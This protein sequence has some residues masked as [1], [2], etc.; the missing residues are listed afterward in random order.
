MSP[1]DGA[2]TLTAHALLHIPKNTVTME[3]T[4][5]NVID[6]AAGTDTRPS[7]VPAGRFRDACVNLLCRL[8]NRLAQISS[9]NASGAT[10]EKLEAAKLMLADLI[11]FAEPHLHLEQ[12]ERLTPQLHDVF[13]KTKQLEERLQSAS[14]GLMQRL[15]SRERSSRFEI[16]AAYEELSK[17]YVRL[18]VV[19]FVECMERYEATAAEK[20]N[21]LNSVEAFVDELPRRW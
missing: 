15:I 16:D 20:R 1:H 2:V 18:F 9:L 11:D 13:A 21:L 5:A 8:E 4:V 17:E 7:N 12:V 14:W 6:S 3:T 10:F 19:F